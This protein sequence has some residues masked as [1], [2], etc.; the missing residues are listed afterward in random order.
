MGAAK[1]Q[2][3]ESNTRM[4]EDVPVLRRKWQAALKPGENLP[5]YE[6]VLLGGLG[7]LA[8]HMV[9]LKSDNDAFAVSRTGRYAQKWIG[10]D[11]WDI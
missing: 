4:F 1:K 11:R 2:A 5:R 8:D 9:L 6:D 10:D 7:R 3:V